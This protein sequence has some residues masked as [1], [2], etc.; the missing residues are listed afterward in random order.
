MI[1]LAQYLSDLQDD[2]FVRPRPVERRFEAA[3]AREPRVQPVPVRPLKP[4]AARAAPFPSA[5]AAA[6]PQVETAPL[7]E[8][9]AARAALEAER[10]AHALQL[11]EARDEAAAEREAQVRAELE[12]ASDARIEALRAELQE[13]QAKALVE[14]RT[15]WTSE[16]ADRLAD[17]M[18][19]QMAV[20][21][22]AMRATVKGVLKPLA[23]D[24]R[25]RRALEDLADA[26]R[27][28]AP[29]G[30]EYRICAT[31]PSDLL[32]KFQ[33]KLGDKADRLA[34]RPDEKQ[35]DIRVEADATTIETRLSD[36][37]NALEK[38][39]S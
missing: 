20:F 9:Q 5:G 36:W 1:P 4:V 12:A 15:R 16:Q 37:G 14:E 38:A 18:I 23:M 31:G 21:E 32:A 17:L 7:A 29:E 33:A 34:V 6:Q 24:A 13:N 19:L 22:D 35:L 2:E 26:V 27:V 11:A 10:Q 39:L 8:L 25:Q 3:F 30:A 28:I